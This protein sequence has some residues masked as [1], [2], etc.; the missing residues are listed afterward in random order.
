[1]SCKSAIY[2]SNTSG[3]HYAARTQVPFGT[4]IRRYGCNCQLVGGSIIL[5]GA[6]YYGIDGVMSTS[7][8]ATGEITAQL[9][10]DGVAVPGASSTV[11]V[12]AAG[13]TVALPITCIVRNCGQCSDSVLSVELD[14]D[15]TLVSFPAKV[16]K[17]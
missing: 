11:T 1:M 14:G 7:V 13:D 6:G 4:V 15:H 12:T 5:R 8:T 10:R 3:Q 17:L 16:T 2:T 9:Y